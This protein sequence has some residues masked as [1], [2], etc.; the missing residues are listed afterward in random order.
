MGDF[1]CYLCTIS[2]LSL[3]GNAQLPETFKGSKSVLEIEWFAKG[4][5]NIFAF[6]SSLKISWLSMS[7][8]PSCSLGNSRGGR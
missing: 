7:G 8:H 2:R 5:S 6:D 4:W 1:V 3:D